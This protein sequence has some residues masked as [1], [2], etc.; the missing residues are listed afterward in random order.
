MR[1][2]RAK[3]GR[4][5]LDAG[6]VGE[7]ELKAA[8]CY[9]KNQRCLLGA[10]LVK[11]GFLSEDKL[12]DFLAENLQL[13]RI[14]LDGFFSP[15]EV[16]D[17][18]PMERA[19]AFTVFPLARLQSSSGPVLRV[20]M[21]D[22]CNL[23]VIDALEFMTGFSILPVLASESAIYGAIQRNYVQ[24]HPAG[25]GLKKQ[26]CNESSQETDGY[27]DKLDKLIELLENKG[28]LSP[29]EVQR[30]GRE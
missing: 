18:V 11:L 29:E 14:N 13:P 17:C 25:A 27:R 10:S 2:K 6:L 15:P 16:L 4:L 20:A 19:F 26:V 24:N 3:L 1:D 8:L 9:Q 7:Q 22:P 30:L 5:L 28:I 21:A 23:T 12:L